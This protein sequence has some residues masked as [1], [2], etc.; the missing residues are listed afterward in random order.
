MEF[1]ELS[2]EQIAELSAGA[3]KTSYADVIRQ[4]L[5]AG[6]DG[7][8]VTNAFGERKAST[9]AAGLKNAQKKHADTEGATVAYDGSVVALIRN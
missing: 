6:I 2:T 1:T 9:V 3:G 7:A 5:A 8:D 4:F